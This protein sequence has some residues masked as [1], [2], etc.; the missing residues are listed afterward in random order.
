[1]DATLSAAC[2]C[3]ILDILL[4]AKK[5]ARVRPAYSPFANSQLSTV[6]MPTPLD[7][8]TSQRVSDLWIPWDYLVIVGMLLV[9]DLKL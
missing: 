6:S 4:T 8:A 9:G 3:N 5:R 7:R 1:M 2:T